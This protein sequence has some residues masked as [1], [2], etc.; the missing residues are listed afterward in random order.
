MISSG[1]ARTVDRPRR[2]RRRTGIG[3]VTRQEIWL[4]GELSRCLN[5]V[6]AGKSLASVKRRLTP[7]AAPEIL[8]LLEIAEMLRQH[9]NVIL[10]SVR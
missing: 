5:E 1:T 2:Q 9:K 3:S 8:P 7:E 10:Q 6:D 4:A